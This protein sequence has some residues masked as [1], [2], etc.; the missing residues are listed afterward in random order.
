MIRCMNC[1]FLFFRIHPMFSTRRRNVRVNYVCVS[2]RAL[3]CS[4]RLPAV[5]ASCVCVWKR[6]IQSVCLFDFVYVHAITRTQRCHFSLTHIHRHTNTLAS[7]IVAIAIRRELRR[8]WRLDQKR[9]A[10]FLIQLQYWKFNTYFPWKLVCTI[11]KCVL[12]SG[13]WDKNFTDEIGWEKNHS[14][15]AIH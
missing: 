12:C 15:P 14:D 2:V 4:N 10:S 13:R 7:Y 11:L 5:G 6:Y 3:A 1:S 9:Y 8:E